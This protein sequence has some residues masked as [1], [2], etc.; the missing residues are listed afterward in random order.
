M[1]SYDRICSLLQWKRFSIT[2]EDVLLADTI[3]IQMRAPVYLCVENR[4]KKNSSIK[5]QMRARVYM[6]VGVC[7][8]VCVCV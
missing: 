3:N 8:C 6:C 5:V 7:V 1:F 4:F 2:I